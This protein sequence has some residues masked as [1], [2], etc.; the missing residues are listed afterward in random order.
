MLGINEILDKAISKKEL[1]EEEKFKLL[2]SKR[3]DKEVVEYLMNKLNN[4]HI[5]V[6][7]K[8]EGSLFELMSVEKL[9]GWC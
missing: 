3:I 4:L 9:E 5:E 2:H 7:G 1:T 6:L 8:Y